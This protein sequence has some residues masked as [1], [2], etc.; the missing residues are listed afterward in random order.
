MSETIEALRARVAKLEAALRAVERW[1]FD[2]AT[3]LTDAGYSAWAP[4]LHG[5]R[6]P[7]SRDEARRLID[8]ID[9][10]SEAAGG[11]PVGRSPACRW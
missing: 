2:T 7:L 8:E 4:L 5:P 3:D 11:H 9:A 1:S 6:K 10:L